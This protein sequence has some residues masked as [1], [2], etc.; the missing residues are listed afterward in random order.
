LNNTNFQNDYPKKIKE[1]TEQKKIGVFKPEDSK[2]L[3]YV[4]LPIYLSV[5]NEIL[6]IR[7]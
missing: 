7:H 1:V 5:N 2:R 6:E 3:K 4:S